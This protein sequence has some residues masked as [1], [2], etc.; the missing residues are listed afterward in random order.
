MGVGADPKDTPLGCT[1]GAEVVIDPSQ[2]RVV[3]V[4]PENANE[5]D[6]G[7][8]AASTTP[9][10]EL[11]LLRLR[12]NFL[13]P[14]TAISRLLNAFNPDL[15]DWDFYSTLA[16]RNARKEPMSR[17]ITFPVEFD[18]RTRGQLKRGVIVGQSDLI[19]DGSVGRFSEYHD[20]VAL[21]DMDSA[22]FA[23]ACESEDLD[24]M[25]WRGVADFGEIDRT[26]NWQG[27]ATVSAALLAR[28]FYERDREYI[29]S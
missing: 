21:A 18:I 24:W 19:E 22:G 12:P 14:R 8:A 13:K 29:K 17:L 25:V 2:R 11:P 15:V 1:V 9:G 5:N 7:V 4:R 28:S 16:T 26:Q 10:G 3:G 23:L 6:S 20:R 27:A